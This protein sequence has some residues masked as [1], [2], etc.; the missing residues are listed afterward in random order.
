M[1]ECHIEHSIANALQQIDRVEGVFALPCGDRLSIFT[2]ISEDDEDTYDQIYDQER[3]IIRQFE[4][5][6]FD[7]NVIA[8]RG[9]SVADVVASCTPIWQRPAVSF[10]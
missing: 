8:R 7:F 10:A 4:G 1:A 3:L 9:R 2:V 5:R 6:Q